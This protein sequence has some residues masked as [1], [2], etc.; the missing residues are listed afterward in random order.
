M[1]VIFKKLLG[2]DNVDDTQ[3]ISNNM[4]DIYHTLGIEATKQFLIEEFLNIMTGINACHVQLLCDKMTHG[5]G[6]SSVSRYSMRLEDN[7]PMCRAS[8]EETMDN[9]LKAGVYGQEE[10]TQGVSSSIM[11]GKIAQIGTGKCDL[12]LDVKALPKAKR[13]LEEVNEKSDEEVKT[14]KE[15]IEIQQQMSYLDI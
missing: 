4:W 13:V 11:C 6:I 9:F 8:F 1:E 2:H 7:G 15:I 12:R 3:T 10:C 5:G 14:K